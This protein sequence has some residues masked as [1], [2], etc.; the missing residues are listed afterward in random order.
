MDQKTMNSDGENDQDKIF[1]MIFDGTQ[2]DDDQ[3]RRVRRQRKK[4]KEVIMPPSMRGKQSKK[5]RYYTRP[6]FKEPG[7][8]LATGGNERAEDTPKPKHR[9]AIIH[10]LRGGLDRRGKAEADEAI[11]PS[12]RTQYRLQTIV[13]KPLDG[14]H[15]QADDRNRGLQTRMLK[16][17][18]NR[19]DKHVVDSGAS[20]ATCRNLDSLE[21][22]RLKGRSEIALERQPSDLSSIRR[23]VTKLVDGVMSLS[24][25][26]GAIESRE[27]AD[28]GSATST[29]A[30][31]HEERDEASE[32]SS[33]GDGGSVETSM[34]YVTSMMSMFSEA[35][36]LQNWIPDVK[37]WAC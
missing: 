14:I 16:R 36:S 12:G 3:D 19:R 8:K 9:V 24:P 30:T 22:K 7:S 27:K 31:R 2:D 29:T 6:V 26:P 5:S 13:G 4:N 15:R 25:S 21:A 37:N 33:R 18:E 32:M 35:P 17:D 34:H 11:E 28:D 23:E 20:V 1:S 10:Q